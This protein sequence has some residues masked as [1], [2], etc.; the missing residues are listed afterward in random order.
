[1]E[2]T[3]RIKLKPPAKPVTP[4]PMW[5]ERSLVIDGFPRSKAT[6]TADNFKKI[7]DFWYSLTPETRTAIQNNQLLNGLKVRISGH[8]SNTDKVQPNFDLGYS[9]AQAVE[10]VLQKLSG[11]KE[12][13][14]FAPMSK[15]ERST[16]TDDPGKEQEDAAQ[17]KVVIELWEEQN[18][19]LT[20]LRK[21]RELFGGSAP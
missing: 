10:T 6:I 20:G 2:A 8:T 7:E 16:A 19:V 5:V 1:M 11:N 12:A 15:G 3:I 13:T 14:N 18:L 21:L 4:G 17:R 9:R